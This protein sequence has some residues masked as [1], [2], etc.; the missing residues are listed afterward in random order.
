MRLVFP[1]IDEGPRALGDDELHVWS[2]PLDRP[3]DL[4]PLTEEELARG[5]RFK[6]ERVRRQ[7]LVA[8]ANLRWVLAGYLGV[9]AG[10]VRFA[11]EPS[12]KPVLH[13]LHA[14]RLHFNVSHSE[15][16][17]LYAVTLRGRVGVDVELWR[18]IP[19]AQAV[20]ERFFTPGE[21]VQFLALPEAE[22]QSAFLRAW[23]RKEA[24]LKAIGRGVQSLDE[25]EVTFVPG[26]AE[27]VLRLGDDG[28][29]SAKWFLK[30]WLPT[31]DYVAAVATELG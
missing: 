16:L 5:G 13:P 29:C 4:G 12:G 31:P 2:A 21:G 19:D 3:C 1:H 25:C 27:A 23:T 17:A 14:S 22:R 8:R 6:M 24:V 9:P 11:Y 15:G 26:E 18:T 10:D 20:V 28:A 30:S 7:F